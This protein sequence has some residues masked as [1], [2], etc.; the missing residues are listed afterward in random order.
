MNL[1]T[2]AFYERLSPRERVLVLIV[3]GAV[4]LVLNLVVLR[5]LT[6][7]FRSL[8]AQRKQKGFEAETLRMYVAE[9]PRWAQR[10]RWLHDKQPPLVNRDVAG[11]KLEDQVKAVAD[12][13]KVILTNH[14]ILPA[15][16]GALAQNPGDY[17]ALT[18]QLQARGNF[19]GM[20]HFLA[21]VQRPE[22]FIAFEAA[23][24]STDPADPKVMTGRFRVA[25]WFAPVAGR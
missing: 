4:F 1:P 7:S 19:L 18:V 10:I 3:G 6:T 17:Q 15:P 14:Q 11:V 2:F 8:T 22:D 20:I 12:Q 16:T 23:S 9:K 5:G 25:K 24:L 21:A 13:H